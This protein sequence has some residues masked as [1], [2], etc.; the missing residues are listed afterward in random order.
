MLGGVAEAAG[1]GEGNPGRRVGSIRRIG[2]I[3]RIGGETWPA[4]VRG[5]LEKPFS[6]RLLAERVEQAL[7]L[8][9]AP[10]APAN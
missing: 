7:Q 10:A 2:P 4:A 6:S 8:R 1:A 3:R 9:P 5:L